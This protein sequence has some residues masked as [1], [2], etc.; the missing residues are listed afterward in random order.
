MQ[1]IFV[2]KYKEEEL[3]AHLA[4]AKLGKRQ[5]DLL[6]DW[7]DVLFRDLQGTPANRGA[8]LEGIAIVVER[9]VTI[10]AHRAASGLSRSHLSC[11]RHMNYFAFNGG[12]EGKKRFE[13]TIASLL[14]FA[15]EKL[16][17]KGKFS[18]LGRHVADV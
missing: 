4:G 6:F 2:P 16:N 13:Q 18:V 10:G 1:T 11:S 3:A 14:H 9:Y 15:I 17:G 7:I 8:C 5:R 12:T